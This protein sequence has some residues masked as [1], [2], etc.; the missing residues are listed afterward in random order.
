MSIYIHEW[1]F[2]PINC[3]KIYTLPAGTYFIGDMFNILDDS[4]YENIYGYDYLNG[5]YEYSDDKIILVDEIFSDEFNIFKGSDDNIFN[6]NT[7]TISIVSYSLCNG[8]PC[9][10]H[11]Y[12][13]N[14]PV[15]VTM[16]NGV[17]TFTS[18]NFNL[19]INTAN[20]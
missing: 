11:V 3:N 14:S 20:Y 2:T 9:D 12:T 7:A 8:N 17:F 13:F 16:N 18:D 10:G 6:V 15:N 19:V 1:K 4:I 5:L